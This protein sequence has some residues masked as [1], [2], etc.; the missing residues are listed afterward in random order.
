MLRV[1]TKIKWHPGV[2]ELLIPAAEIRP[3]PQ[4]PNN[5]D[6]DVV[7]ESVLR[8]GVYRPI[9]VQQSTGY[10]LAG[11]TTFDALVEVQLEDGVDQP[12]VPVSWVK[13]DAKTAKRIVLADNQTAAKAR[14]DDALLLDLLKDLDNDLLGT[15]FSED[16]PDELQR[17]LD[18]MQLGD[19]ID[20]DPSIGEIAL[21]DGQ[22]GVVVILD[23]E[24]RSDFYGIL[25]DLDY[26]IDARNM[27]K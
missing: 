1:V 25:D 26:V 2:A 6:R 19:H 23:A 16:D 22:I 5:G 17:H 8:N 18:N 9:I 4:N 10:I 7:R 27:L 14:M 12:L 15:G 3:H 21:K 24:R 11:H 20:D 13:C